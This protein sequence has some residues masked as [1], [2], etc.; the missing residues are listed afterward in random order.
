MSPQPKEPKRSEAPI[1]KKK[2]PVKKAN[3][4]DRQARRRYEIEFEKLS[5]NDKSAQSG[6]LFILLRLIAAKISRKP[7]EQRQLV[8]RASE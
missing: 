1:E 6:L 3:S 8:A 4:R 5:D 2:F 7:F